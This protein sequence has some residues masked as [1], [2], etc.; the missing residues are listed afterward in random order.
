MITVT[1]REHSIVYL[2][3]EVSCAGCRSMAKLFW[4][5]AMF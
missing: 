1:L 3:P 5:G 4:A 2:Y